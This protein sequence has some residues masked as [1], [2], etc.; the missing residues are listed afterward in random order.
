MAQVVLPFE[1]RDRLF[2]SKGE[3]PLG[4]LYEKL[5]FD[6]QGRIIQPSSL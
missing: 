5:D 3:S 6:T 4:L 2:G 1:N